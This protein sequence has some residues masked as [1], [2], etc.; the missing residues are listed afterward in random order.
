MS[1]IVCITYFICFTYLFFKYLKVAEVPARITLNKSTIDFKCTGQEYVII[2]LVT[3]GLMGLLPVLALHLAL[4]EVICVLLLRDAPNSPIYSW[5]IKLFFIFIAWTIIGLLYTPSVSFVI[6]MILKYLYPPLIALAASAVVD[7]VVIFLKSGIWSRFVAFI[8]FFAYKYIPMQG[9]IFAGVF[10]NPAALCT[11]YATWV[12]FSLALYS[13]GVDKKKNLLWALFFIMPCLLWVYRTN[14]FETSVALSAFFFIKY[15]AKSL[16]LIAGMAMLALCALFYIP[17]VKSKMY[18]RPDEVTISDF[19]TG[20][21]NEDNVNTSGRNEMWK[22]VTPFYEDHP[23]I[24]SGTGRVQ[25]YF[26][27]EII[28]FGRGGQLHNDL[29]LMKCDNGLI[30]LGLFLASYL[31]ILFHCVNIYHKS[32]NEWTKMCVLTA[33][34]SLFGM[35]VTLY[36]DNTVS[37]SLATLGIPWA[38]YGMALGIYRKEKAELAS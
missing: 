22:K 35:L 32:R 6:R 23:L 5:P 30:G 34:A 26:Y 36:S 29:L 28:G 18:F 8:S 19:L 33:G 31:A 37:Y 16:P 4:A 12:V 25:K 1:L 21:V 38:F 9:I 24:G 13:M 15:R 27:T 14:I 2:L 20:N 11:N 10:W 3:T 7:N 17:S